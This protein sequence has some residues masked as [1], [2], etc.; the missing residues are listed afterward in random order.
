MWARISIV[1]S[2]ERRRGYPPCRLEAAA[3]AATNTVGWTKS[4]IKE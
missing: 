1:L 3:E 4:E 2:A